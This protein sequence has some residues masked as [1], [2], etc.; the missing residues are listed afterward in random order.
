MRACE[1]RIKTRPQRPTGQ[2]KKGSVA[3]ETDSILTPNN[4]LG[5]DNVA[6]ETDSIL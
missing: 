3:V 1:F 2:Q 4:G 5:N 6:V